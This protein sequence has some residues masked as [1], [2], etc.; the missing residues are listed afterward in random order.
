MAAEHGI[1][2]EDVAKALN[3]TPDEIV[4]RH[5]A[6]NYRVAM[7]G[8]PRLVLSHGLDASLQ[9]PRRQNRPADASRHQSRSA[10]CRPG[11][12]PGRP[13]GWHLLGRTAVRTYQLH[14]TRSSAGA[15]R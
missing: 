6:G 12:M 11:A 2:L 8:L 7:I 14:A 15:R 4:E 5:V 3:T 13:S 10:A 1:R 9:M